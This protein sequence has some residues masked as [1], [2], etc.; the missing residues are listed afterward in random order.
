MHV[1]EFSCN[2]PAHLLH[3]L[4]QHLLLTVTFWGYQH[5]SILLAAPKLSRSSSY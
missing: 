3:A 5:A 4:L 2:K 1:A